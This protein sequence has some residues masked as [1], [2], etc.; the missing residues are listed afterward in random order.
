MANHV[1]C[2]QEQHQQLSSESDGID[3]QSQGQTSI[4]TERK[5]EKENRSQALKAANMELSKVQGDKRSI[6]Q[7]IDNKKKEKERLHKTIRDRKAKAA[8]MRQQKTGRKSQLPD[9]MDREAQLES[10]LP[11]LQQRVAEGEEE[12]KQAAQEEEQARM[13]VDEAERKVK[14]AKD[15]F[16]ALNNRGS[17]PESRLGKDVM[18]TARLVEKNK[19]RFKKP[20]IGPIGLFITV[21]DEKWAK[22]IGG[23]LGGVRND[24]LI[25]GGV[26][27]MQTFRKIMQDERVPFH[28][29]LQNGNF[30]EI[31]HRDYTGS[32]FTP[33]ANAISIN[34][35]DRAAKQAI[36]NYLVDNNKIF[37]NRL[38]EDL[39]EAKEH[40]DSE[41]KTV[42]LD[43]GVRHTPGHVAFSLKE[44]WRVEGYR[45]GPLG[46]TH[47]RGECPYTKDN[48][49]DKDMAKE[50]MQQ[51][52]AQEQALRRAH[53]P[54]WGAKKAAQDKVVKAKG[55]LKRAER[56]LQTIKEDI[57]RERAQNMEDDNDEEIRTMEDTSVYEQE[58]EKKRSG[59][60]RSVAEG[61]IV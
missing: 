4:V 39:D 61:R 40:A 24:W 48:S 59:D 21:T 42:R 22:C 20:P 9:L 34:H 26:A 38:V 35:P 29:K 7:D 57:R 3:Q 46:T 32:R 44:G 31:N 10:Q 52:L 13:L 60:R 19:N 50:R 37:E 30:D 12:N 47:F 15:A 11:D 25:P 23:A 17:D 1:C 41:W 43:N 27:D 2:E 51:E 5:R 14:E 56:E 58:I 16:K 8:K 49:S 6:L 45:D 53:E 18:R 28:G 55:N 36:L 54:L 33:V